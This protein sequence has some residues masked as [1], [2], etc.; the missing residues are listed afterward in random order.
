MKTSNNAILAKTIY[1]LVFLLVLP[2]GL[3]IWA[4]AAGH[5]VSLPAVQ[6]ETWGW[7]LVLAGV[8]LLVTGMYALWEYGKGLPMNGYPPP[9]FVSKGVFR[10][11]PHPIYTGFVLVCFGAAV[12]A[13]SAAGLWLVGPVAAAGCAA[14]VW[15]YEQLDLQKRFPDTAR[16]YLL[17]IP[18]ESEAAPKLRHR[19]S[20]Y[21]CLLLPWALL[22]AAVIWGLGIEKNTNPIMQ[23]PELA[24]PDAVKWFLVVLAS[25]WVFLAPMM[26][27]SQRQLRHF[28]IGGLMSGLTVMYIAWVMPG[29]GLGHISTISASFWVQVIFS[30]SW[31][32]LWMAALLYSQMFPGGRNIITGVAIIL[33]ISVLMLSTDPI[34]HALTGAIGTVAAMYYPVIWEF[35]RKSAETIANSWKE[36]TFGPVRVINHGFYVGSAAFLGIVTGGLLAGEAYIWPMVIFGAIVTIC[37]GLWGQ[38]IEGSDKLKRPFGFYGAMV[39]SIFASLVMYWMEVNVWVMLGIFSVFMPW[40]QG[41]GRFRCLINGCCHGAETNQR[42]GIRYVHPRSRVCFVSDMKGKPLHPTPLYSMLWL[43]LVGGLQLRLWLAGAELSLIF[44]TYLILNGLGRFVEEAYRG[45]PQTPIFAKLRLYQWAAIASMLA[46]IIATSF[47]APMPDFSLSL[48]WQTFVGGAVMWIFV[49]FLM[50]I[51]FPKSER[52]FSRLT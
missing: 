37:S 3:W 45:E 28:F 23:L 47:F 24:L 38:F 26:A 48:S 12:Y 19:L 36:W 6:S 13:G 14:L 9:L 39:G 7:V 29:I 25:A 18:P 2:V 20:V 5:A 42:L 1:S 21:I 50:G 4:K 40:V 34:A 30:L 35:L 49:Q 11:M 41:I 27:H 8:L 33:T 32:W 46:G 16:Q 52:R 43:A 10:L 51:D 15:G 22:N 31:F 44:G 17:A